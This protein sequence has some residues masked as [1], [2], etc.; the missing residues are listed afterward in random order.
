MTERD[1]FAPIPR[2]DWPA[3]WDPFK[4]TSTPESRAEWAR[5]SDEKQARKSARPE[6][7]PELT[8]ASKSVES[9]DSAREDR[10]TNGLTDSALEESVSPESVLPVESEERWNGL[11]PR[12]S[13]SVRAPGSGLHRASARAPRADPRG[14]RRQG[15]HRS[16]LAHTVR[17]ARGLREDDAARRPGAA[18]RRRRRLP[19]VHGAARRS[20]S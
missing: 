2:E 18:S 9:V 13:Y 7:S 4:D 8:R 16:S 3:G 1:D 17:G 6:V 12:V 5:L 10:R 14:H 15:R 20:R 19:A 11:R